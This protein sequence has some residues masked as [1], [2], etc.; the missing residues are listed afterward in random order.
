MNVFHLI[1]ILKGF[2]FW[3]G[4]GVISIKTNNTIIIVDGTV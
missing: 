4:E 1:G 3:L 2:N